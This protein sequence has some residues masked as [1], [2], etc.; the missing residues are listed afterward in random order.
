MQTDT[1]HG[2][3]TAAL[4]AGARTA[5]DTGAPPLHPLL[6]AV[7]WLVSDLLSTLVFV[8]VYAIT[9]SVLVSV[10][11]AIALGLG[12][13]VR[14]KLRGAA[15]DAMQWLSL[16]LVV[17][18]GGASLLTRDPTFVMVK[19]TLVYLAVGAVMLRSGWMNRYVPP[20]VH[21]YAADVTTAFGYA[22]AALMFTTAIA[23]LAMATLAPH[24]AWIWFIGVFP[25]ASKIAL[26]LL[27]YAVT[28]T[29]VRGR[30][31]AAKAL[32][33]PVS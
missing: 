1:P 17:V 9:N 33:V 6:R 21:D 19:P 32:A 13:V 3:G 31:R 29:A 26:L 5:Q 18:F 8:V 24:A 7:R 4:D 10:G 2:N 11:L 12:Q 27:Q 16:F 15:I 23:N 20:I 22:W 28:R 25:I 14:Q 30:I